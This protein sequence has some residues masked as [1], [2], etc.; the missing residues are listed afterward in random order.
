ML[1]IATCE[2][3]GCE[4]LAVDRNQPAQGFSRWILSHLEGLQWPDRDLPE[5]R[6]VDVTPLFG[7][8]EA[9]RVGVLET[10]H[11]ADL[12]RE[13]VEIRWGLDANGGAGGRQERK[14]ENK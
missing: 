1:V 7:V 8:V 5:H 6:N 3:G 12:P 4:R 11:L 2:L 13:G 9:N 14:P 10:Y